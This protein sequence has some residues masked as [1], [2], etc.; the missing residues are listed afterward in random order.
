V[1]KFFL[2]VAF[3]QKVDSI[4]ILTFKKCILDKIKQFHDINE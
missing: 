2:T 1:N 3:R 4:T